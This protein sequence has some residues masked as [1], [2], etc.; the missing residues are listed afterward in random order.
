M[1]LQNFSVIGIRPE[2]LD[3][4]G[5]VEPFEWIKLCPCFDVR[6]EYKS[7]LKPIIVQP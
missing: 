5:I 3:D 6:E 7:F 4:N 2:D 1:R